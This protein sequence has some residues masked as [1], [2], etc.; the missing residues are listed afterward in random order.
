MGLLESLYLMD[1]WNKVDQSL[2]KLS[3]LNGVQLKLAT[4]IFMH[5][6]EPWFTLRVL[7]GDVDIFFCFPQLD[8]CHL[9]RF[10]MININNE[11]EEKR[12]GTKARVE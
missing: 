6:N 3:E 4:H 1:S 8:C 10:F 2:L 9:T 7:W 5:P 12:I 11:I